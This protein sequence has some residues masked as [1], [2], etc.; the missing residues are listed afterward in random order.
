M[1][2]S[3]TFAEHATLQRAKAAG[4]SLL[5]PHVFAGSAVAAGLGLM[6]G[7]WVCPPLD[8]KAQAWS[9]AVNLPQEDTTWQTA[10]STPPAWPV[11]A[12]TLPLT[13]AAWSP[14]K[15]SATP[16]RADRSELPAPDAFDAA[17]PD[18]VGDQPSMDDGD[19]AP[20]ARD[21]RDW[22]STRGDSVGD[23]YGDAPYQNAQ[24]GWNNAPSLA[25]PPGPPSDL[26]NS[27]P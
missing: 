24:S 15:V 26:V 5:T 1:T 10:A 12:A 13:P 17:R 20:P 9:P 2:L 21:D 16:V 23:R 19:F 14:D 25:P 22:P 6:I 11:G 8:S 4:A 3:A 18:S 7:L 27:M